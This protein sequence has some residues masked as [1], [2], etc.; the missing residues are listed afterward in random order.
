VADLV[1]ESWEWVAPPED[2]QG[3]MVDIYGFEDSKEV[4]YG[5]IAVD[6]SSD[7]K[8]FPRYGF[9]SKFE[10]MSESAMGKVISNLNRYHI[11]GLQFYDWAEKHHKPLAGTVS[12]PTEHWLDIARR[13]VAKKTVDGYIHLAHQR[14]M[15]AMS[16]NLCYGALNDAYKDGLKPEWKMYDDADHS[17]S[18]VFDIGDFLKSPIYLMDASNREWQKYIA[19]RNTEMYA[20]FDFDGYHIDQLGD[21]GTKYNYRGE[22]LYLADTYGL[23][24]K[25][26]KSSHPSKRLVFNAV[27]QYGQKT[28]AKSE[29]D[30]L[31]T[32]VWDPNV[33]YADLAEIILNNYNYSNSAKKSIL[34][35][36]MNYEIAEYP[37]N[38]NP[39]GVLFTDAVIFAFGGAHLE[40][41]EHML[42]KE[43]F[44][45]ENLKMPKALSISLIHYYDFMVGYE[46]LL[47][48]GGRFYQP[49]I[50]DI[51]G[52]VTFKN[53]QPEAGSIAVVGK[54]VENRQVLHLINFITNSQDWRDTKG[55][56]LKP[57]ALQDLQISCDTEQKIN[58]V[59]FA[60]PDFDYGVARELDFIEEDK[61]ITFTLPSLKYWS[62]IVME[63]E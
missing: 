27:N 8:R 20:V 56:K 3:Y 16:Y 46:N 32:E 22:S 52:E 42:G 21:W 49:L 51:A 48:D 15:K 59:W 17:K 54:L 34:A 33:S 40:L 35:A 28:I 62:M 25:A 53:W 37:G 50:N 13:P 11:N 61:K 23:F 43:Y 30:F 38:F 1:S 58:K 9:L 14:G 29:V 6:V 18:T 5:A 41:G 2:Y 26:M 57:T 63:Y 12:A 24:I 36:Y 47:R 45:N 60:S 55:I 19:A 7:W 4:I 44:P 10:G 39:P 31:Y